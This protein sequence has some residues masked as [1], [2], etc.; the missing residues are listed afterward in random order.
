ME[1]L[2]IICSV[3]EFRNFDLNYIF[4]SIFIR[5]IKCW[6]KKKNQYH[7]IYET[8]I[9]ITDISHNV[10]DIFE[11][12]FDTENTCYWYYIDLASEWLNGWS[13]GF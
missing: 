11:A 4:N 13:V 9:I 7:Q 3:I 2:H 12:A 8:V 6:F 1:L 5:N 10:N